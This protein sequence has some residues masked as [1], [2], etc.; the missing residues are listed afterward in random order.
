MNLKQFLATSALVLAAFGPGEML[1]QQPYAGCWMPSYVKTWTPE[2]DRDVKFNRSRVPLKK[3]VVTPEVMKANA[4]QGTFGQIMLTSVTAKM[5]SQTSAQGFDNFIGYNPTYWQYVDKFVNWGGADDEGL[6]V[7]PPAGTVDAAHAQGVKVFANL[8]F[9]NTGDSRNHNRDLLVKENGTYPVA[10][11][12]VEI[13]RYY[14]FDGYFIN[15]EC[16]VERTK[17]W[18]PWVKAFY[19]KCEALGD[20][21]LE[22][23]WYDNSTVPDIAMLKS[24]KRT[25]H[26]LDYGYNNPDVKEY[27]SQVGVS[28][29]MYS[30]R[31]T[32][33]WSVHAQVCWA[34]MA[35]STELFRV[36]VTTRVRSRCSIPRKVHGRAMS[37]SY[38]TLP[39]RAAKRPT[40][41]CA[42]HSRT[43][44]TRGSTSP[45]TRRM[46]AAPLGAASPDVSSRQL[47]S[48]VSLLSPIS[49]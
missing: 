3:R 27:A 8:F 23:V 1:A 18:L 24:G 28:E 41:P 39:M 11:K 45:A 14:G 7:L 35:I 12:L 9:H 31:Y 32:M 2:S 30:I 44:A 48:T 47:Q 33:A 17:G 15:N 26:F 40:R 25:C 6:V 38:S 19:D 22:L 43:S 49:M 29:G 46:L 37:T 21:N 20:D 36:V 10:E 13:A 5:C 16:F 4:D 42:R 34:T